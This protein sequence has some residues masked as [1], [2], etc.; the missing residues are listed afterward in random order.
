MKNYIVGIEIG[1]TKIQVAIGT[2]D[3]NILKKLRYPVDQQKGAI[4]IR[5]NIESAIKTFLSDGFKIASIG[6]GFGGPIDWQSGVIDR[7]HHIHGWDNFPLRDWLTNIA[8]C[9]AVVD[10]D[11][12]VATLAEATLGV[13]KDFNIVFYI[14]LGSGV[15]GGLVHNNQIYHGQKPGE[16]EIGHIRLDLSGTTVEAN[17]S[18]WAIDKKIRELVAS[19][20]DSPITQ[21]V[22]TSPHG[23]EARFL[24]PA[25]QKN[26]NFAINIFEKLCE[27]LGFALSHV[28]HLVH[29]EI[30][31]LGGGLSLIG[32]SLAEKVQFYLKKY[33]MDAFKPG[34]MIAIAKLKED[35][36]PLGAMV[37][38]QQYAKKLSNN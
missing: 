14:T 26:D 21:L 22:K 28:C 34:P 1:G 29:P 3:F 24:L 38:A 32:S 18:G 6:A 9:P 5:N 27:N 35:A 37:L 25:I 31:I 16:M 13:G 36:V 4:G 23:S 8:N 17:C 7:S 30:I 2:N 15:G 12:N 33:L 11:A 20:I 19:G 10:N